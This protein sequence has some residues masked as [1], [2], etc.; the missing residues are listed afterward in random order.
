MKEASSCVSCIEIGSYRRKCILFLRHRKA[1][2]PRLRH[3]H[4]YFR[5]HRCRCSANVQVSPVSFVSVRISVGRCCHLSLPSC[6]LQVRP[7]RCRSDRILHTGCCSFLLINNI[8]SGYSPPV[9]TFKRTFQQL[10]CQFDFQFK[11][12]LP[13]LVNVPVF[14]MF[15]RQI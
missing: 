7:N 12:S 2:S 3:H 5:S 8:A 4:P 6:M 11:D 1:G 14:L 10:T 13:H 9:S 15:S